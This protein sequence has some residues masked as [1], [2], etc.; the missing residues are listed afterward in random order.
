MMASVQEVCD[1]VFSLFDVY[2]NSNYIGEAVSQ[3]QHALQAAYQAEQEGFPV[4]IV[5]GAL[6]HDIG[7]LV[8]QRN[9]YAPMITEGMVLGT[10]NHDTVGETYLQHL[11]FPSEVT[12]FVRGHVNAKRYLVATDKNYYNNLSDASKMTL[13]HQGGPMTTCEVEKF[14][15][16]K[17]Y[18]AIL[19]MRS[20]DEKAKDPDAQTPSLQHY[21][22]ICGKYLKE[23]K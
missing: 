6:L 20:W 8:G 5:L 23:K 21:K 19:R 22:D 15:K 11:G 18:E 3:I 4:E 17:N 1:E 2:G 12:S 9:G 13:V 16:D 10:P 7:H 14:T